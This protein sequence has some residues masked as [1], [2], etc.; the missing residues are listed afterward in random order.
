MAACLVLAGCGAVPGGSE[1][2]QGTVSFYVSD[3]ANAIDDFEHL[4]VTVTSVA[5]AEGNATDATNDSE[6]WQSYD[7]NATVDLTEL[8]GANATRLGNLSVPTGE[9]GTVK[10]DVSSVEGTLTNGSETDVKLP[11]G[12][13]TVPKGLTVEAN[14]SVE[15]VF[16]V[17][18]VKG[19]QSG[20][21]VLNPVLQESGTDVPIEP[22]GEARNGGSDTRS[23]N[24]PDSR[25]NLYV[26]DET[27]AVDQFAHL[28]VTV[29]SVG[30]HPATEGDEA[31]ESEANETDENEANETDENETSGN[32]TDAAAESG[33]WQNYEINRTTIDLTEYKGANATLLDTL[34]VSAGSYDKVFVHVDE[35]NGTLKT[36]E[37]VNVKLPSQ[38]LHIN[39][40]FTVGN[41][42]TV[43]FVFD[44]SVFEA[45]NSGKYI[46]K[47]VVSDS[48]TDAPIEVKGEANA[49]AGAGVGADADAAGNTTASGDANG[50]VEG[51]ATANGTVDANTTVNSTIEANTT[52]NAT[53]S[54]DAAAE[55]N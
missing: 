28:N 5:F 31:N 37:R 55:L 2:G 13:L 24:A 23:G 33:G 10:L 12:G 54:G 40:A 14:E 21:Y 53:A 52:V 18:V 19:G 48:G 11:S 42:E 29:S 51:D 4:N 49:E 46:L 26:S 39:S 34:N 6:R 44:I 47:P 38:K 3:Q 17:S 9:Y 25:M 35:V 50:T 27:N 1:G 43:D 20:R 15:F 32:E 8:R 22:R 7:V 36:G 16:D 45:G 30:I 41:N